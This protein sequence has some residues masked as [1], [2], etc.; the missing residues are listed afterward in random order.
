M[1]TKS[2]SHYDSSDMIGFL[3][4]VFLQYAEVYPV[5]LHKQYVNMSSVRKIRY[6][7]LSKLINK[8]LGNLGTSS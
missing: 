4:D 2:S 5:H 8:E 7:V 3:N 1:G 6:S